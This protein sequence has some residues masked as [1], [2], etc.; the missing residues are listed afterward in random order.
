MVGI[1]ARIV[2]LQKY[3]VLLNL[4]QLQEPFSRRMAKTLAEI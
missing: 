1:I 2:K 4:K 3:Q